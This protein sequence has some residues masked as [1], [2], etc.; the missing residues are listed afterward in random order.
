MT[1][2]DLEDREKRV[3]V[4]LRQLEDFGWGNLTVEV[5]NSEP[6]MI[7]KETHDMVSKQHKK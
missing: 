3:I 2:M 7:K 4:Q 6:V 1:P 5:R